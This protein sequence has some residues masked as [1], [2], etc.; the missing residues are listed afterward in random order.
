M[1]RLHIARRTFS[2]HHKQPFALPPPKLI[3]TSHLL[4]EERVPWYE[5]NRFYPAK[6]G[7]VLAERFQ[8]LVKIGYGSSSTTWLARDMRKMYVTVTILSLACVLKITSDFSDGEFVAALKINNCE[9]AVSEREL[10][11]EK[12]IA[13]SGSS[14]GGRALLRTHLEYFEVEGPRGKHLCLAYP[15]MREPLWRFQRRFEDS[16][17]PFPLLK[18]YLLVLLKALDCLHTAC[19]VVHSGKYFI[20]ELNDFH[21]MMPFEDGE[22]LSGFLNQRLEKPAEYKIDAVG[23]HVFRHDSDFGDLRPSWMSMTPHIVDFGSSLQLH[24]ETGRGLFPIQPNHYRAPEVT[25]GFPWNRSA[26]IWSLGTLIWDMAQDTELFQQAQDSNGNYDSKA[27]LAEMIALLGPPPP[28]FIEASHS[29]LLLKWPQKIKIYG[30]ELC[31]NAMEM[32]GGPFFDDDGK[33]LHEHLIP[34]RKIEDTLPLLEEKDRTELLSFAK[35]M[36]TWDPEARATARELLEHPFLKL[37]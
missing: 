28:G 13:K 3:S 4:D 15:P 27:H 35:K 8:I 17:I 16:V 31:E 32:F 6:P 2:S 26:D 29:T 23:R 11:I 7:E 25:L 37:E 10:E 22:V 1:R 34:D 21:I 19:G 30:G 18:V 14:H 12:H 36:L 20:F 24:G 9:G 33:F 5:E